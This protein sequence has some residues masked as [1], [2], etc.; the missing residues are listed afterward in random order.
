MHQSIGPAYINESTEI[1]EIA[2]LAMH[3]IS[4]TQFLHEPLSLLLT[5]FALASSLRENKT[6]ATAV[7]F[8]DSKVELS[9]HHLSQFGFPLVW[10]QTAWKVGYL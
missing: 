5:P 6:T 10:R 7:N 9:T 4:L 1:A 8:Y 2:D 3:D